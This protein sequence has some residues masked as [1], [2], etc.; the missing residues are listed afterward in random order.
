ME[1]K[2]TEKLEAAL[3]IRAQLQRARAEDKLVNIF[4]SGT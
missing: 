2:K 4:A 3:T 1:D